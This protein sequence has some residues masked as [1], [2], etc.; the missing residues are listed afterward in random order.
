MATKVK[1]NGDEK[2]HQSLFSSWF[3]VITHCMSPTRRGRVNKVSTVAQKILTGHFPRQVLVFALWL[4]TAYYTYTNSTRW[5]NHFFFRMQKMLTRN[6]VAISKTSGC[7]LYR[8]IQLVTMTDSVCV[9][10]PSPKS[11][12][13]F[14]RMRNELLLLQDIEWPQRLHQ[15][16]ADDELLVAST[17]VTRQSAK[18]KRACPKGGH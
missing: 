16:D 1:K 8:K 10:T 14:K 9:P 11:P 5:G 2:F 13:L 3:A 7:C 6:V 15:S 4:P 12:D 17:S 18:V